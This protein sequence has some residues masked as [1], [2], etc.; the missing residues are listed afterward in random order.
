MSARTIHIQTVFD[1]TGHEDAMR[2][3]I[4][5]ELNTLLARCRYLKETTD[6]AADRAFTGAAISIVQRVAEFEEIQ[7]D[8]H[9]P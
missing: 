2:N 9:S 4:A 7:F 6:D 3:Q 1:T 5:R 8:P